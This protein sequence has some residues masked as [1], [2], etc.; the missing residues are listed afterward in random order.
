MDNIISFVKKFTRYVRV[1]NNNKKKK[2]VSFK[3]ARMREYGVS[4][5]PLNSN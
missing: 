5:A 2:K 1:Y 4:G 3:G